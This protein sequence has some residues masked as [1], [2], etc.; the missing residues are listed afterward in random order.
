VNPPHDGKNIS[1]NGGD[2]RMD[3][4]NDNTIVNVSPCESGPLASQQHPQIPYLQIY[5][6]AIK[7]CI[8]ELQESA[9]ESF[10]DM[11]RYYGNT[12]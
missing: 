5:T 10:K 1:F 9:T 7:D 4:S 12:Q 2:E 3:G 11:A 6:T 8:L